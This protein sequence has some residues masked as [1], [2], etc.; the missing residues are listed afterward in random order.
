MKKIILILSLILL[1]CS[2]TEKNIPN[3]QYVVQTTHDNN[4]TTSGRIFCDSV[5]MIDAKNVVLW[6][7][8]REM[9]MSAPMF[10]IFNN[11]YYT[12]KPK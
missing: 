9:K 12:S 11:P 6:I 7:D 8:G 10:K 3:K 2:E 1:S 4:W 5:N